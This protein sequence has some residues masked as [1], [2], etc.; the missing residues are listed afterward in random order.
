MMP[1]APDLTTPEMLYQ[2]WLVA[3]LRPRADDNPVVK[4]V[5]LFHYVGGYRMGASNRL[6][7]V[8]RRRVSR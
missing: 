8:R 1:T 3:P 2:Q 4:P 6:K 7:R 5:L